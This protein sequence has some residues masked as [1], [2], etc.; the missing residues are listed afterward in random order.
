VVYSYV[1]VFFVFLFGKELNWRKTLL[2]IVFCAGGAFTARSFYLGIAAAIA[3]LLL[4]VLVEKPELLFKFSAT[5][6][7]SVSAAIFLL[8]GSFKARLEAEVFPW[9]FEFWYTY[10]A[11]GK[12]ETRSSKVLFSGH[13]KDVEGSRMLFGDGYYIVPGSGGQPWM[14]T[15][16]GYMRLI[17]FGGIFYILL[18]FIPFCLILQPIL[19]LKHPFAKLVFIGL[20]AL[21]LVFQLKGD[22][23]TGLT[24][25]TVILFLLGLIM[26]DLVS[27]GW[28][29]SAFGWRELHPR[30]PLYI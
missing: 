28:N 7:T 21:L 13:Y 18:R 30:M 16:A 27:E 29:T 22:V 25:M 1:L 3:I 8:P 4:Y 17:Y 14:D 9:L 2:I 6:L 15:D 26:N 20:L 5:V 12:L 10:K 23:F 19:K 11:T 24:M